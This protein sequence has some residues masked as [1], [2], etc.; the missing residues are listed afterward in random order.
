MA[1]DN[2]I[3]IAIVRK[4]I[5]DCGVDVDRY[6]WE[7]FEINEE[8]LSFTVK[9]FSPV[10]GEIYLIWIRFDNYKEW[11]L[12]IDF[13]DPL[14]GQEGTKNA[15]PQCKNDGFFHGQALICNPCSRKAYGNLKGPHP[16]WQ[17]AEWQT[18]PKTGALKNLRAILLAINERIRRPELYKGRMA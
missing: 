9:M 4:E 10:D 18:N 16:E 12:L 1:V 5:A 11:P 14:N 7:F 6:G 3:S 2:S 17:Y 13:V 15:Y 8:G